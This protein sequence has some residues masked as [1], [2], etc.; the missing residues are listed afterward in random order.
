MLLALRAPM[1]QVPRVLQVP[2]PHVLQCINLAFY[3]F[4]F[5]Y[6]AS[7]DINLD[8]ECFR[9]YLAKFVTKTV[10]SQ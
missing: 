9:T 3:V 1:R 2:V 4:V 7:P 10:D 6:F 5:L 8:S